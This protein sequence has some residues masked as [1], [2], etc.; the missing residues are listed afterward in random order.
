MKKL[1]FKIMALAFIAGTFLQSCGGSH[2]DNTET[3]EEAPVEEVVV[4]TI[5]D[6]VTYMLPSPLQVVSLFK[7]A[8]LEYVG[9]ITNPK[10]NVNNYNSKYYQKLNFGVYAADMAYAITNNQSQESI[11]YLNAIRELSEKI[12]MTDVINSIGVAERL[13]KNVG[14]EDSLV[15]IMADL[16]MQLDDYLDENGSSYAGSVIFAG[17]WVETM[18]LALNGNK[19]DNEK[20]TSRL[21]E[22]SYVVENIILAVTQA[23]EDKEYDDL[24]A[25][26]EGIKSHF[27]DL[28]GDVKVLSNEK[29][30]SLKTAIIELRTKIING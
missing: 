5:E 27:N 20:L 21:S 11:N 19:N 16:Q 25:S 2:E 13:E 18:Y 9:G 30:D 8:G 17:A 3:I 23:N 28:N 22:Q 4:E 29:L 7:N 15:S 12:W 1:S 10:E 26:L 24:I 6:D 14:N